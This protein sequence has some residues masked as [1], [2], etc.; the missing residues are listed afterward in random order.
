MATPTATLHG[1]CTMPIVAQES[2]LCRETQ[3][4]TWQ[5]FYNFLKGCHAAYTMLGPNVC[6]VDLVA[7]L[8]FAVFVCF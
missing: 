8:R 4:C 5:H 2:T 3:H 1:P 6:W 7:A